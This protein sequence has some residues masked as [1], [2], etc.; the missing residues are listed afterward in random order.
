MSTLADLD[1]HE[2]EIPDP[3]MEDKM[4]KKVFPILLMASFVNP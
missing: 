2:G 4:V 3:F 1:Q